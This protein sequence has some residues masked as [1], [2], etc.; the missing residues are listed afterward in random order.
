LVQLV[1]RPLQFTLALAA[2]ALLLIYALSRTSWR[3]IAPLRLARRRTWGQTLAAAARMYVA[4]L[5]LVLG[6]GI[7]FI[8]IALLTALLQ[9]L[10]LHG[11]G[12]LGVKI[13]G[14]GSGLLGFFALAI[15][16]ALTLL[17]L[18]LVQR[19]RGRSSRS[20]RVA[21]PGRCVLICSPPTASGLSSARSSSRP[22]SSLCW[23]APST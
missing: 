8:P 22:P 17:G 18:G 16:T 15:S 13:G 20:T 23:P 14:G 2:L 5:G 4:N 12:V 1:H 11:T 7:L 10:M 6:I 9:T 19:R 21:G 3:P